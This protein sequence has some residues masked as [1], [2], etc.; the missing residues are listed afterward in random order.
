VAEDVADA[1]LPVPVEGVVM[2]MV[3]A[4]VN[5]VVDAAMVA[6]VDAAV[7][8]AMET[9]VVGAAMAMAVAAAVAAVAVAACLVAAGCQLRGALVDQL[10]SCSAEVTRPPARSRRQAPAQVQE[11]VLPPRATIGSHARSHG[12]VQ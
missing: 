9:T 5:A 7:D 10:C 4:P 12:S 11:A 6:A 1:A 3:A 2:P 8:A